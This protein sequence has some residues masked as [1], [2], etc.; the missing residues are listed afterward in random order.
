MCSI[1]MCFDLNKKL[2][3]KWNEKCHKLEDIEQ[4]TLLLSNKILLAL[5]KVT[6]FRID[7]IVL[8]YNRITQY[9][10]VAWYCA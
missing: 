4:S 6:S 3:V 9:V 8:C 2:V 7:R 5:Q 10:Y 1:N